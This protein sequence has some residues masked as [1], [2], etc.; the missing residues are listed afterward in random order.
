[1]GIQARDYNTVL[2]SQIVNVIDSINDVK[3]E[4]SNITELF[5]RATCGGIHRDWGKGLLNEEACIR[6]MK[7][8][9]AKAGQEHINA[10]NINDNFIKKY[11]LNPYASLK[12]LS[13][14]NV[15]HLPMLNCQNGCFDAQGPR[16]TMED[17]HFSISLPN[18]TLVGVLDGHG[19]REVADVASLLVQKLFPLLLDKNKGNVHQT[20]EELFLTIQ[21]EIVKNSKLNDM[22]STAVVCYIEKSTKR[23]YTATL[24]DSEANFYIKIAGSCK[25]IPLS[26]VRDW[27]SKRDEQRAEKATQGEY[28]EPILKF[29]RKY[30]L[31]AKYRRVNPKIGNS[32]MGNI[33]AGVNVSRAFGDQS[34]NIGRP[35]DVNVAKPKITLKDAEPGILVLACDGL[36]DYVKE[37]AIVKCV[38]R[39]FNKTPLEISTNLVNL[40]LSNKTEDNVTVLTVKIQ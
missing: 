20:F 30:N 24:G 40:A 21:E 4:P 14:P 33:L 25:S 5:S 38:R 35:F 18:G 1:M 29:W 28:F 10:L 31:P 2:S 23:I 22:G 37:K 3:N 6:K 26:C 12:P 27:S 8:N 7:K 17:A 16:P 32:V 13:K 9:L 36:K 34:N 39:S 11:F 19:G 15:P